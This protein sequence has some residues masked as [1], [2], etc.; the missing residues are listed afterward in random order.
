MINTKPGQNNCSFSINNR[1]KTASVKANKNIRNKE[2]L[3]LSYG[4]AYKLNEPGVEYFTKNY[5]PRKKR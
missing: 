1:N 2:E 5:Y 4:N 3:F